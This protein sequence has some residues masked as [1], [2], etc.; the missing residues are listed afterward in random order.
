VH[1]I[2]HLYNTRWG[3]IKLLLRQLPRSSWSVGRA[4][5]GSE[6][7]LPCLGYAER[8]QGR[9]S[10]SV[11]VQH[12]FKVKN[13]RKFL[14]VVLLSYLFIDAISSS[15]RS[16]YT[17]KQPT[18]PCKLTNGRKT[19]TYGLVGLNAPLRQG[20]SLSLPTL[21]YQKAN[22]YAVV[23]KTPLTHTQTVISR[24]LSQTHI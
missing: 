5:L 2:S 23:G 22:R 20:R 4:G 11:S 16:D 21:P 17:H 9:R 14:F 24:P 7:D 13:G 3:N 15:N 12:S 19:K 18:S 1:R 6:S 10:W 8:K